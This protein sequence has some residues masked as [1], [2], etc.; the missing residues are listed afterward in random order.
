MRLETATLEHSRDQ[1]SFTLGEIAATAASVM[2]HEG[3]YDLV[4]ITF[5]EG[6]VDVQL[7]L[8]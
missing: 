1:S 8:Y 2:S 7:K 4:S 6:G 3:S 5:H